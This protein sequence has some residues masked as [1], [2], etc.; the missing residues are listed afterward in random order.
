M[1][2]DVRFYLRLAVF[3]ILLIFVAFSAAASDNADEDGVTYVFYDSFG[4][5]IKKSVFTEYALPDT[6]SVNATSFDKENA[7]AVFVDGWYIRTGNTEIDISEI[8]ED[9]FESY[10]SKNIFVYPRTS[11]HILDT[12]AIYT[13]DE[14][15]VKR[16]VGSL[17]DY[18]SLTKL[19]KMINNAPSGS[20]AVLLYDANTPYD[21]GSSIYTIT[22]GKRFDFDL[23][24]RMLAQSKGFTSGYGS[25]FFAVCEGVTLNIYSTQAGGGFYQARYHKSSPDRAFAPGIV[26]IVGGVK[27]ATLNFGDIYNEYG[28]RIV[29]SADDIGVYGG[30]LVFVMEGEDNSALA[31]GDGRIN[32][33][34]DGAFFY[35]SLRSG[36]AV[37][38]VRAPNVYINIK[39]SKFYNNNTTYTVFHDYAE[40]STGARYL[41]ESHVY[42]ESCDFICRNE[43]DTEN[44]RLYFRMGADSTAYFKD[45][46]IIGSSG[47][48]SGKITVGGGNVISGDLMS[49]AQFEPGV[50]TANMN[51]AFASSSESYPKLYNSMSAEVP[52]L[53][54]SEGGEYVIN[55]TV[56]DKDEWIYDRSFNCEITLATYVSGETYKRVNRVIWYDLDGKEIALEYWV[57]GSEL[58]HRDEYI[59]KRNF[60]A[61]NHNWVDRDGNNALIYHVRGG[62]D[63]HIYPRAKDIV[64]YVETYANIT[65][66]NDLQFNIYFPLLPDNVSSFTVSGA[67]GVIL[68]EKVRV[69]GRD[70]NAV[71]VRMPI[72]SFL[73]YELVFNYKAEIPSENGESKLV[74]LEYKL[75]IGIMK[76]VDALYSYDGFKCGTKL[77]ALMLS[78]MDYKVAVAKYLIDGFETYDVNGL[79]E[80]YAYYGDVNYHPHESCTCVSPRAEELITSIE[81]GCEY[82]ELYS[83]GVKK[84]DFIMNSDGLFDLVIELR[85]D[86]SEKFALKDS[87][88][89]LEYKLLRD[90]NVYRVPAL[91]AQ[92]LNK[93]LTLEVG[94]GDLL[95]SGK[96]SFGRFVDDFAYYMTEEDAP[97][98]D[99]LSSLY[100][101]GNNARIYSQD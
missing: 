21:I 36:Y 75:D 72:G 85:H 47:S 32:I 79:S 2:S 64:G 35:H 18:S 4:N 98:Y 86:T 67:D 97:I 89:S 74:D 81:K 76:Y 49:K 19:K 45:C 63:N 30:S 52:P 58:I 80:F 44:T 33:N 78:I 6:E 31:E 27:N 26:S 59:T 61:V 69:E 11:S 1:R 55:P 73:P 28:E 14:Y 22:E 48:I 93:V 29:D 70:M 50:K 9:I 96:L 83:K 8:D 60:Y 16:L 7:E 3:L 95:A 5:E 43:E 100:V 54:M 10:R 37:F 91:P 77:S 56:F 38:T 57:E 71:S 62:E 41:S 65:L 13:T 88:A 68:T 66:Y 53:I 24:G 42:A 82:D 15:G 12:F 94:E 99:I 34:V 25:Q 23:N 40:P 101:Y 87:R 84:I 46:L 51:K 92:A 20:C 17:S 39:N 90:G